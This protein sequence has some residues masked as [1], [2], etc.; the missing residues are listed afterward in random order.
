MQA[1]GPG[2][3]CYEPRCV[4]ETRTSK[5]APRP[6]ESASLK[7]ERLQNALGRSDVLTCR[8][9]GY[10]GRKLNRRRGFKPVDFVLVPGLFLLGFGIVI[11]FFLISMA[12][13]MCPSCRSTVNL[14]PEM[15]TPSAGAD[16]IWRA[17][18]SLEA[19]RLRKHRLMF[20]ASVLLIGVPLALWASGVVN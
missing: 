7:A 9:C 19:R 14:V 12:T 10:A 6:P 2:P 18:E 17:A 4:T 5:A 3:L 8:A 16:D 13:P 1:T 11:I 15:A 20:L